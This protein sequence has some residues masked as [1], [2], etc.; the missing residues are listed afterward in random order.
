MKRRRFL[1][2]TLAAVGSVTV[3]S[4]MLSCRRAA[5]Q[6][7]DQT[8][9]NGIRLPK[10]FSSRVIARS[11]K[12]VTP[13]SEYVWHNAPD[14]GATF[15]TNEGGWIYVSNCEQGNG[16]GGVG[17]I[18]FSARGEVVK[19]YS[20]LT[21][22]SR[23]CGGGPTPWGTWLS[24]EEVTEGKVWECDPS[25][26][27][28]AVMLPALGEFNHESLAVDTIHNVIYLT[29]D[30]ADG[31][32]YRFTPKDIADNGR[33]NLMDGELHVCRI[34]SSSMDKVEWLPIKDVSADRQ[35]LR[36]QQPESAAFRGGEGIWFYQG[37]LY[38]VTKH[39]NKVWRLDTMTD[40]LSVFYDDDTSKNPI[41][42]GV[43]ALTVTPDGR[44]WVAEDGGDMQLVVL[45]LDGSVSVALQFEGHASSEVTGIAFDPS[46]Q[47]L[48]LSSQRG[49]TGR[50][51]GGVTYEITGNFLIQKSAATGRMNSQSNSSN[52]NAATDFI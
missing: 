28:P 26:K 8:D 34:I 2:Y 12:R 21:G 6:G 48:Y 10:G 13:R 41:L 39:D 51:S 52:A 31:R 24:G 15:A 4:N 16:K 38:F 45:G 22:T 14:G 17:A 1:K 27:T 5:W 19:A 40:S 33:Y 3:T 49:T 47:R 42:T 46:Y 37:L 25:G 35:P 44:V 20:I 23:N 32:L 29:E 36:Y 43:D 18:E 7:D 30:K 11:G 50:N 9:Q